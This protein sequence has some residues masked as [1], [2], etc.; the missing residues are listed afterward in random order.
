MVDHDDMKDKQGKNS[1]TP[2][3]KSRNFISEIR[4]FF[5]QKPPIPT[6]VEINS[7]DDRKRYSELFLKRTGVTVDNYHTLNIHR[8]GI[9]APAEFIFRELLSW[10]GDSVWWPN[11][12]ARPVLKNGNLEKI[13]ITLFGLSKNLFGIRNGFF[14]YHLLHLF[15]LNAIKI[16]REPD[17]DNGRYMLYKCSGGYP[18]GVFAM[19]TRDSNPGLDESSQSQLFVVVSFNFY[20]KQSLSKLRILNNTWKRIHNRATSNIMDRIKMKCEWDYKHQIQPVIKT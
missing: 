2:L 12:I 10:D 16:Q 4:Y 3:S 9:D 17:K 11:H 13:K 20:G 18:I 15:N 6:F 14:G 19:Y 8:I 1:I 5:L 7:E